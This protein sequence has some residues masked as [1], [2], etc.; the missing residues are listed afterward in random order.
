MSRWSCLHDRKI[1]PSRAK[2]YRVLSISSLLRGC[3]KIKMTLEAVSAKSPRLKRSSKMAASQI[4]SMIQKSALNRTRWLCQ[5]LDLSIHLSSLGVHYSMIQRSASNQ[6]TLK[7]LTC[8][9][10]ALRSSVVPQGAKSMRLSKKKILLK[11]LNKPS[12]AHVTARKVHGAAR[13][14]ALE[15]VLA[16]S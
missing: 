1:R 3:T 16:G 15:A 10:S 14:E 6:T 8:L 5:A 11:S 13:G 9:I 7:C 12:W 2:D 4:I